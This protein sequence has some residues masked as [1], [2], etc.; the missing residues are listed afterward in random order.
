M[1]KRI[2]VTQ[3]KVKVVTV[4]KAGPPE[5][6]MFYDLLD[7]TMNADGTGTKNIDYGFGAD[8][9][10]EKLADGKY[11]LISNMPVFINTR[12][13]AQVINNDNPENHVLVKIV[14]ISDMVLEISCINYESGGYTNS[15]LA[16]KIERIKQ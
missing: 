6:V 8:L 9:L 5:P 13:S 14:V 11:R 15:D 16:I 2:I 1:V 7:Y 10:S 12:I 4:S 3:K